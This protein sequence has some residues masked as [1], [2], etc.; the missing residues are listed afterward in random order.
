MLGSYGIIGSLSACDAVEITYTEGFLLTHL[1]ISATN[2]GYQI[3][4]Q[5]LLLQF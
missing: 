4:W 5:N 3:T 1:W 2:F